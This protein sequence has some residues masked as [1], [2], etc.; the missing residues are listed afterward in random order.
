MSLAMVSSFAMSCAV[1]VE[2]LFSSCTRGVGQMVAGMQDTMHAFTADLLS[3]HHTETTFHNPS[4]KC[5]N[6]DVCLA[7]L[8]ERPNFE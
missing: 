5:T 1:N 4:F 3:G 8:I 7:M 2:H 6:K